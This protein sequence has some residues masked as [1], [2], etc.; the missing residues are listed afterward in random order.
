MMLCMSTVVNFKIV[1]PSNATED[2]GSIMICIEQM[3]NQLS[4]DVYVDIKTVQ[5]GSTA[6]GK[7]TNSLVCNNLR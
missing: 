2:S 6:T 1:A 3:N 7:Q 4:E 5:S